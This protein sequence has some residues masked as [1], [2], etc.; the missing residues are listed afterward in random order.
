M[1]RKRVIRPGTIAELEQAIS[2][3][4]SGGIPLLIETEDETNYRLTITDRPDFTRD[5]VTVKVT[6]EMNG[7][8]LDIYATRYEVTVS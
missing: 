8:K 2:L 7:A 5:T 6:N 3:S 4:L 1:K